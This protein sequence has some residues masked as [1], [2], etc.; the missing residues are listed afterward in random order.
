[1]G[2]LHLQKF[3]GYITVFYHYLLLSF[4]IIII[5]IAAINYE[6]DQEQIAIF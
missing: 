3:N 5:I 2:S 4:I 6:L 1:M